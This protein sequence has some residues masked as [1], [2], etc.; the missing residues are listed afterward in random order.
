MSN[1]LTIKDILDVA[2]EGY[3][4]EFTRAYYDEDGEFVDDFGDTLARFVVLE[5]S[6]TYEEDAADAEKLSVAIGVIEKAIEDL[7]GVAKALRDRL[8]GA[9]HNEGE[10]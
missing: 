4:D 5:I 6:E 1:E 3:P 7:E 2:S 10:I 8:D 9:P